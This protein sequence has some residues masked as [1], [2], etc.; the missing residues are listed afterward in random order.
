MLSAGLA[1]L[2]AAE[3]AALTVD[4]ITPDR[5]RIDDELGAGWRAPT[6]N[7]LLETAQRLGQTP[8][9]AADEPAARRPS[10]ASPPVGPPAPGGR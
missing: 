6:V 1:R 7:G 10:A 3:G 2:L 9:Q 8:A 5:R 4:D